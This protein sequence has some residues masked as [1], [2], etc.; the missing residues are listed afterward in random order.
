MFKIAFVQ[1]SGKTLSM[2]FLNGETNLAH[3]K[4]YSTSPVQGEKG[5]SLL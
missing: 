1:F 4:A 5:K 2:F 3:K